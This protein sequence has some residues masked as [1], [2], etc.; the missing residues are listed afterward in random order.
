MMNH[1]VRLTLVLVTAGILSQCGGYKAADEDDL[2]VRQGEIVGVLVDSKGKSHPDATIQL[3]KADGV[4]AL[5]SSN[6]DSDGRFSLWPTE[7][8]LYNVIGIL[9]KTDKVIKQEIEFKESREGIN[10]GKL[11]GATVG[12]LGVQVATPDGVSSKGIKIQVLGTEESGT[13]IEEGVGG[14]LTIPEGKYS[15]K[16][17]G[18]GVKDLI[19]E[20]VEIKSGEETLL[21]DVTLT[22]E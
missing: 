17:S 1:F 16:F 6:M 22:Q 18:D 14:I 5:S 4:K 20:D 21:G 11:K 15:V 12:A 19:R 2:E 7:P 9:G 10:I 13:T 8:G 3:I